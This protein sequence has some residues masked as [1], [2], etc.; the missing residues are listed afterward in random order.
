MISRSSTLYYMLT[1]DSYLIHIIYLLLI[2]HS[3]D[4]LLCQGRLTFTPVSTCLWFLQ[5]RSH[6][7]SLCVPALSAV[8]GS[9]RCRV[10]VEGAGRILVYSYRIPRTFFK[11]FISKYFQII[12]EDTPSLPV[13]DGQVSV[14]IH[15]VKGSLAASRDVLMC[16]NVWLLKIPG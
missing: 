1:S 10:Q 16:Y 2:S 13:G 3:P 4:H 15:T 7:L 12:L 5:G 9:G 8:Y 6:D 11:A 14:H